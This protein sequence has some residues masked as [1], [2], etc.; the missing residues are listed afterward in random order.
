MS[1]P[2]KSGQTVLKSEIAGLAQT[3]S[4]SFAFW[5]KLASEWAKRKH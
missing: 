5:I 2:G 4:L 1:N 3:N